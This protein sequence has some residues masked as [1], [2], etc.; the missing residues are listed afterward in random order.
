MLCATLYPT[1]HDCSSDPLGCHPPFVIHPPCCNHIVA[2]H[3]RIAATQ[4]NVVIVP[5]WAKI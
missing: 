3:I 5:S 4:Y 2:L 1:V